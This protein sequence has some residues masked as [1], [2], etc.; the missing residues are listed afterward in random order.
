MW[1][2]DQSLKEAFLELLSISR[3]K[4]ALVGANDQFSNDKLQWNITFIRSVQDWEMD[5]ITSFYTFCI[6]SG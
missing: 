1:G 6:L 2:V 5:S 3:F 4:E